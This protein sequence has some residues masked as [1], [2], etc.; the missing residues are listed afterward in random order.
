M[1]KQIENK[2]DALSQRKA[3]SLRIHNL[4]PDSDEYRLSHGNVIRI[5]IPSVLGTYLFPR[6]ISAF[7][8]RYPQYELS[9]VEEGTSSIVQLLKEGKLDI[10]FAVLYGNM[11][12][13][14]VLPIATGQMLVCMPPDHRLADMDAVSM[15]ALRDEQLIMLK[16]GTH[17]RQMIIEQCEKFQFSPKIVFSTSQLQTIVRMVTESI[18]ITFLLDFIAQSQPG[19][20]CKPLEEPVQVK[21]GLVWPKGQNMTEGLKAFI[22]VVQ[23]A[24]SCDG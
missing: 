15:S 7:C 13:L 24:F 20:V 18:G 8:S 11:S 22:G 2:L 12:D 5:G 3:S 10:G 9:I 6:L 14:E 21:T 23:E 4:I 1:F 16:K 17:I 19:I